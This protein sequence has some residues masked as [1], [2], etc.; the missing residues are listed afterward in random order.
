MKRIL[1]T[2]AAGFAGGV[3]AK[4]LKDLG[5]SVTGTVHSKAAEG[6]F[7]TVQCDLTEPWQIPGEYDAIV[8]TAGC[9]A[10]RNPT[11]LDYKHGNVDAMEHL[12]SYARRTGIKRVI[13]FSTIGIYGEF[14]QTPVM[15]DNDRIN[16]DYYG[17]TK[18][19][20]ERM[21][22]DESEIESISLRMP[23]IIGK[24]SRGVWLPNTL[25][26]FLH[27]EPVTIYSPEFQ[28]KNF[29]WVEDLVK[30]V[31]M[32]LEKSEWKYD[33]LNLACTESASI[34]EIVSEMKKLTGSTSKIIVAE[35]I[36]SS[37]CLD[38]S[39]AREMGYKSMNP[40]EIV[41]KYVKEICM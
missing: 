12:L 34:R 19:L 15:E 18:Y 41:C 23:G 26:K 39:K 29:V 22:R 9:L 24:G 17:L 8:H 32:L 14:R 30:F 33:V 4:Y 40:L 5:Y 10:Y 20:A 28:T 27:N 2:G 38:N 25:E 3:T 13:Y 1:V 11:V 16:Q 7:D 6:N 35:G 31:A 21:L 37:F 36:R